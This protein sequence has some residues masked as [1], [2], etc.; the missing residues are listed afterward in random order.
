MG[1]HVTSSDIESI[2]A[3][4]FIFTTG[5][6]TDTRTGLKSIVIHSFSWNANVRHFATQCICFSR[7]VHFIWPTD[8]RAGIMTLATSS[9]IGGWHAAETHVCALVIESERTFQFIFSAGTSNA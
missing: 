6:W 8:N 7:A 4:H 1:A 2:V 9:H 3:H 5:Y